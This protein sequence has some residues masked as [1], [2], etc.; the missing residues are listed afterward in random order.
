MKTVDEAL[1]EIVDG[2]KEHARKEREKMEAM[3]EEELR[4]Y[5]NE[6]MRNDGFMV[7]DDRYVFDQYQHR[8]DHDNEG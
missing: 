5:M 1:K 3:T 7:R 8:K 2:L 6:V 4:I